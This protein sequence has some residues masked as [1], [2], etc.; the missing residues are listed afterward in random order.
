MVADKQQLES[1]DNCFPLCLCLV[2]RLTTL[3]QQ[4]TMLNVSVLLGNDLSAGTSW[5]NE[6]QWAESMV[7]GQA[8]R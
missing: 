1:L 6:Q 5:D 2:N 3:L 7:R 4:L 8:S